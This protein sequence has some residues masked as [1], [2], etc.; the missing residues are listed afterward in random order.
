MLS[1]VVHQ[2][3]KKDSL[4]E[5]LQL[6]SND[7]YTRY[8]SENVKCD[9]QIFATFVLLRTLLKFF[10]EYHGKNYQQALETLATTKIVPMNLLEVDECV[11]TFKR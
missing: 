10:D 11:Q 2:E 4:R 6:F 5:R 3:S 7:I 1:Q 8:S 9:P